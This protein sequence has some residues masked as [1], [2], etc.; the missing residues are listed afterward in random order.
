MTKSQKKIAILLALPIV[1]LASMM[2]YRHM[3]FKTGVEVVLPIRGYDPRDLL[4]GYYIVYQ[5]DYGIPGI[6]KNNRDNVKAAFLCLEKKGDTESDECSKYF[7]LETKRC[8]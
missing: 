6:C 7:V 4:S 3:Q 8:H 5:I 2:S 1:A